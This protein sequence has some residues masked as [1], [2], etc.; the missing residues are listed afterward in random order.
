[1][2]VTILSAILENAANNGSERII[3]ELSLTPPFLSLTA[4]YKM[5]GRETIRRWI[6]EGLL[7]TLP[8]QGKGSKM[9]DRKQLEVISNK[10]NRTTY[11][12]VRE[13]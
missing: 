9:L 7:T 13:R 2:K 8:F 5:Y 10:N 12:P 4:A 6:S 11:L 3:N 1:M